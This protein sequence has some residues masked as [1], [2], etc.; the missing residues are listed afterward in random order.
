MSYINKL[1]ILF[2]LALFLNTK[3]NA[4][5]I[6]LYTINNGGG[7]NNTMEWSIG[8][9]ASIAHFMTSG[10]ILNTG[11]LQPM[12]NI[13]TA[14]N[15]YGPLVFGPEIKIGPIPTSNLLYVKANFKASGNLSIQLI[16]SKSTIVLTH[17]A[18][19]IFNRYEKDFL[20]NDFPSGVLYMK[21]IFKPFS[22]IAK[23]GI[24]KI[25]KL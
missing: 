19:F 18:G 15:E 14:I 20:L 11:V 1:N 21:V 10:Y 4:Q 2:V 25:I 22:G 6:N 13:V 24:Y 12:T 8:E 17:D 7:Y 3:S 23:V 16:D 9:S 5:S